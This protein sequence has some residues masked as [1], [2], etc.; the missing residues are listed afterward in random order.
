[1]TVFDYC[2]ESNVKNRHM[3]VYGKIKTVMRKFEQAYYLEND[4]SIFGKV[5]ANWRVYI[6]NHMERIRPASFVPQDAYPLTRNHL[7]QAL[8]S[9]GRGYLVAENRLKQFNFRQSLT[10]IDNDIANGK[11]TAAQGRSLK[12]RSAKRPTASSQK[13]K[14]YWVLVKTYTTFISET[15]KF[16]DN[17]AAGTVGEGSSRGGGSGGIA[18]S[19]EVASGSGAALPGR[20][21]VLYLEPE[22]SMA[23]RLVSLDTVAVY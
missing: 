13:D 4:I 15:K 19:S 14:S 18:C 16:S 23:D 8:G 5:Q 1:M 10:N 3:D 22:M 20:R 21:Q 6:I 7:N 9:A 2:Q 11:I 12:K 17:I